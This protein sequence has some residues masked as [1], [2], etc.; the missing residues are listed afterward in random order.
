MKLFEIYTFVD[1]NAGF[2][3]DETVAL[4]WANSLEA[5]RKLIKGNQDFWFDHGIWEVRNPKAKLAEVKRER[6]R[7]T[8]LLK[9]AEVTK[10]KK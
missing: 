6:D 10:R 1:P 2:G 3:N 7:L 4:V 9:A 5:A 8:I